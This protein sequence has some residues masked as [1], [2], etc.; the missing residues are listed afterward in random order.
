MLP[1]YL[2]GSGSEVTSTVT[3]DKGHGRI[4]HRMYYLTTDLSG[5]AT[6]NE[7]A[8]LA[9]I[10]MVRSRVTIGETE[11][12]ETRY[13]IT[14]LKSIDAF[15]DAMRRHRSIENGLHDYLEASFREDHSRIRK[16]SRSGKYG[17]HPAF[18]TVSIET[19]PGSKENFP[20]AA[21]ENLCL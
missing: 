12:A 3:A 9:A 5:L 4:E 13:A 18:G 17:C 8:G 19:A 20:E 7:W 6:A 15:A 10:G 21:A 14:S 16:E 2:I 11:T 1:V